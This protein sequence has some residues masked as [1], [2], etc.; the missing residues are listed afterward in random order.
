MAREEEEEREGSGVMQ[1]EGAAKT[2]R[3]GWMSRE[4]WSKKI[5]RNII[6][7]KVGKTQLTQ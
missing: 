7:T 5:K 2:E 3:R 1:S 4:G 6:R